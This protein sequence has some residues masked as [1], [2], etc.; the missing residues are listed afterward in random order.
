M[1]NDIEAI[2][3]L[4]FQRT[5]ELRLESAFVNMSLAATNLKEYVREDSAHNS[6]KVKEVGEIYSDLEDLKQRL[7]KVA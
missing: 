6:I 7:L 3:K 1:P 2:K 5:H 4:N